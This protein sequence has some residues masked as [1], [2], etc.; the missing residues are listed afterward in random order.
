MN[1]L[2]I[3]LGVSDFRTSGKIAE[4]EATESGISQ[5]ATKESAGEESQFRILDFRLLVRTTT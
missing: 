3:C 2:K 4:R 1:G 5:G